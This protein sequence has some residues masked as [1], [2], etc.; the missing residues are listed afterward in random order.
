MTLTLLQTI[1]KDQLRMLSIAS[2]DCA[3]DANCNR[4]HVGAIIVDDN[5]TILGRGSN[6]AP[7]GMPTCHDEGCLMYDNSCKRTVHAE[8]NAIMN[9][10][11]AGHNVRGATIFV[12]HKPCTDCLKLMT[13]YGLHTIIYNKDYIP[14][15]D[16]PTNVNLV[17]LEDLLK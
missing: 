5:L 15:Y 4:L 2:C 16:Y 8:A 12:T 14:K 13:Q 1:T 9:A 10:T 6:Q 3:Q 17:S 7:E 11:N